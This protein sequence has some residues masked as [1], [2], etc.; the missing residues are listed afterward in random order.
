[1]EETTKEF[2]E[3]IEGKQKEFSY[4]NDRIIRL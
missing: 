4:W 3:A 1:M 2:E